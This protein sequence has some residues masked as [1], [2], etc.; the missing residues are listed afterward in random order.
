MKSADLRSSLKHFRGAAGASKDGTGFYFLSATVTSPTLARQWDEV[1][2]A[3]PKA[4]LVQYDP[5][6]AGT[7][8]A[9]G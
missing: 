1:E 3:Y 7:A 5:A 9:Q 6:I 4:K 2:K 8:F